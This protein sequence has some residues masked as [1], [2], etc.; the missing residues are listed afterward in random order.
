MGGRC[1]LSFSGQTYR[2]PSAAAWLARRRPSRNDDRRRR[3]D[4]DDSGDSLRES[5][6]HN[7]PLSVQCLHRFAVESP[8]ASL[9]PLG[10]VQ[11]QFSVVKRFS[12][13]FYGAPW[14]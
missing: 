3:H 4:D 9:G 13:I 1:S 5:D 10:P 6:S 7:Q 12:V 14:H 8:R 11:G 2:P